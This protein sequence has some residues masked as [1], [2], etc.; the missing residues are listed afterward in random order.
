MMHFLDEMPEHCLSDFKIGN[1][2]VFHGPDGHDIS[3]SAAQHS[4]GL[5]ADSQN[6]GSPCLDG[7]NGRL[8]QNNALIADVNK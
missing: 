7:Y 8:T 1:N 6:I 3:R 5:F 4:L 2:T